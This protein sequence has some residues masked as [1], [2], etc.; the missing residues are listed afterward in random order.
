MQ[1]PSVLSGNWQFSSQVS[2]GSLIHSQNPSMDIPEIQ[3]G[4]VR[5]VTVVKQPN[6]DSQAC[7]SLSQQEGLTGTSG[8]I[9]SCAPLREA[10]IREDSRLTSVAQLAVPASQALS[11]SVEFYLSLPN[12]PSTCLASA[13]VLPQYKHPI[14]L[15]P[16]SPDKCSSNYAV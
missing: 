4:S 10:K 2:N 8:T 6:R 1:L 11:H 7:L 15:S 5:L 12:M 14:S 3:L 13:Q 16:Q 9:F